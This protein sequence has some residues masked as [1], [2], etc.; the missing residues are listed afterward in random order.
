IAEGGKDTRQ[1]ILENMEYMGI[2]LDLA[3][4]EDFNGKQALISAP[5]SKVKIYITPTNEEI[6]VAYFV[7]KVV[8]N[9]RDLKPE[10]MVFRL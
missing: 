3:K 5:D 8:E 2:K 10:E 4:N 9:G 7:K 1:R 6:V